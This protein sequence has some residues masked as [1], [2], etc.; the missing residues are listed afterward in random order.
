MAEKTVKL[1]SMGCGGETLTAQA[2]RALEEADC[3][4]GS[5]RLLRE[6]P[7]RPRVPRL[8]AVRGEEVLSILRASGAESPCVLFSGDAGFY[9]GAAGLVPLL[10]KAEFPFELFPGVSSLQAFAARLRQS[11]QGW[12]L[13]SAHGRNCD[14]VA[15][16]CQGKPAFF[17]TGGSLGYG[18]AAGSALGGPVGAGI[19]ALAGGLL[20]LL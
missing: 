7:A 6:A 12:N 3:L 17:L 19:G 1:V 2:R 5:D 4:I 11:W 8:R 15:A 18:L 13:Y 20:G 16:V 14:P 10:E 9:S